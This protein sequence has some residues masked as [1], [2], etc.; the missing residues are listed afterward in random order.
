MRASYYTLTGFIQLDPQLLLTFLPSFE[1]YQ[2]DLKAKANP[3]TEDG[4]I[5]DTVNT[6]IEYL[7]RDYRQTIASIE[8]M[9]THGEITFDLLY[10]ILV[11]RS[12]VLTRCSITGELQALQLVSAVK[13][14][15]P[16]GFMYNLICEGI[17][18]DESEG[19]NT[20]GFFRTQSRVMLPYFE[21]TVKIS[22]L[23]AYPIQFHPHEAE[24]KCSLIARGKKWSKLT[25]IHHMDYKGTAGFK[26][27]GK[28]IKYNVCSI[29]FRT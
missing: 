18:S 7:R 27:Q 26:C 20:L 4:Y 29:A 16:A 8:N 24:I 6:L 17:D 25:G 5:I 9:T 15:T 21:G 19:I 13:V 12:I 1:I 23:D 3:S 2:R 14:P 22:S 11:P 28:V 10:A